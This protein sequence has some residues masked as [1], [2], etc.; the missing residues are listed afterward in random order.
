ML[1]DECMPEFDVRTS[2]GTRIAVSPTRAYA[3]LKTADFDHWG[4]TRAFYAVLALAAFPA[5][6]RETCDWL[7]TVLRGHAKND[8]PCPARVPR[9]A[10][11]QSRRSHSPAS[12]RA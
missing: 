3:S 9:R 1:L 11:L 8:P 7:R 2:Y 5:A 10:A 6:P 4:L 12:R